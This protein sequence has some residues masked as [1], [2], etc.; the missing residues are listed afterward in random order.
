[1]RQ[2]LPAAAQNSV[3]PY[4]FTARTLMRAYDVAMAAMMMPALISEVQKWMMRLQAVISRVP[5]RLRRRNI[6]SRQQIQR[7]RRCTVQQSG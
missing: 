5:V 7:L 6:S 4:Y 3:S 1:M 2:I